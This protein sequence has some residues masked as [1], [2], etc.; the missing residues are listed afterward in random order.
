[1]GESELQSERLNVYFNEG[2]GGR[3]S[4]R[5]VIFDTEPGT[6]DSIRASHFGAIFRPDNHI[7]GDSGAGYNW[8]RGYYS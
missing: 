8:A 6:I 3:Y 2:M 4:P 7:F 1:M 5:A